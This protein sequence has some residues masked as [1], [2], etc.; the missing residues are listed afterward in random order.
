MTNTKSKQLL[1]VGFYDLLF[2]EAEKNHQNINLVLQVFFDAK[3]RLIK[4]PLVEFEENFS[5]SETR[6]SFRTTD[7]ISGK[8]LILRNDIT[9]Q[10]SRLLATRLKDQKLPLKL[11]Y[12]GDV[13]CAKSEEIYSNRQKTQAG[14]EIIGCDEEKSN[15]EIVEVVL[16]ALKKLT[17]KDLLIEFSLPDF[18]DIF[19]QEIAVE[20]KDEL[21]E[22]IMKKN[23]SLI[24][25]LAG[26]YAGIINEI[27]LSNHNLQEL[28]SKISAQIKSEKIL[29]QLKKAQKISEFFIS[30]N[31]C[32]IELRFDLFGD[33]EASY[34]HEI[35]FDIF[36]KNFSYPIARGGR[37]KINNINAVGATIYMNSL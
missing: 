12:V 31:F 14:F 23:V 21:R 32:D 10:I 19:L 17:V 15:F 11:C 26:S 36:C 35:S 27:A 8:N 30:K 20:N 29:S 33:H 1:P 3:Y 25:N 13:L 16:S 18:L 7:I 9:P 2:D 22:A 28:T 4:T 24:R 6:N 5:C 37:Y 34:H